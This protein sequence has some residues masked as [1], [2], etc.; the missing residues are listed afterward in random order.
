MHSERPLTA[1]N[2][3]LKFSIER[4]NSCI[5]ISSGY[6]AS[7]PRKANNK[8]YL[9]QYDQNKQL[10][11]FYLLIPKA[12]SSRIET[13]KIY[14]EAVL[15]MIYIIT[16]D[17]ME[18]WKIEHHMDQKRHTQTKFVPGNAINYKHIQANLNCDLHTLNKHLNQRITQLIIIKNRLKTTSVLSSLGIIIAGIAIGANL[19]N[20]DVYIALG[21]CLCLVISIGAPMM[22]HA[23]L[24]RKCVLNQ[25]L[26][27]SLQ[28]SPPEQVCKEAQSL[29]PHTAGE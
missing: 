12:N 17:R 23:I 16:V 18:Y 27:K 7:A 8:H 28:A 14:V 4:T 1:D 24:N 11:L 9:L 3:N 6:E 20:A 13:K 5:S 15:Q 2:S 29:L 25:H 21:L 26:L 10:L 19:P 22:T